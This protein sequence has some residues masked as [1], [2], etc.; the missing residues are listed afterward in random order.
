VKLCK[1][2]HALDQINRNYKH[3]QLPQSRLR[4]TDTLDPNHGEYLQ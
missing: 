2:G 1:S 3:K 4:G